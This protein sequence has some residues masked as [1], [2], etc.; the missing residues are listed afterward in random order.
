MK[1]VASS[2]NPIKKRIPN[3]GSVTA[4]YSTYLSSD[5][6]IYGVCGGVCLS[7]RARLHKC[8]GTNRQRLPAVPG[9]QLNTVI[10]VA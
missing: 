7:V 10:L 2:L 3:P 9:F 1:D 6:L 5:H 4:H 8:V